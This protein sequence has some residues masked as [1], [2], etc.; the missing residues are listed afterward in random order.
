MDGNCFRK[1]GILNKKQA[2]ISSMHFNGE[3][4]AQ[5]QYFTP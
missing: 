4:L 3:F 5:E 2:L 1:I